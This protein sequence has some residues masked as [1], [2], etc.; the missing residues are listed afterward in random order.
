MDRTSPHDH[1]VF[2]DPM[3]D[4][5]LAVQVVERGPVTGRWFR[6]GGLE[7]LSHAPWWTPF[8]VWGPA[9]VVGAGLGVV[10]GGALAVPALA[11]GWLVWTLLEYL[12]HR[13]V[14]HAPVR[15]PVSA[16][17]T[18]V[19]HR[20]HHA[21]PDDTDRRAAMPW[22]AASLIVPTTAGAVAWWPGGWLGVA[23]GAGVVLG[24]LWYE[25][26]HRWVHRRRRC[27]TALVALQQHHLAHHFKTPERRFGISTD[28]WD[29]VF[30]T[31]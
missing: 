26:V 14:F 30:R 1:P 12:L 23:T 16:V 11:L 10:Y 13:A 6:S 25:A 29:R 2:A 24:Y 18:W 17:V 19:I 20:H 4:R 9:L 21:R 7:A 3:L 28:L 31:L 22:Q 27:P 5:A 8:M 15:G